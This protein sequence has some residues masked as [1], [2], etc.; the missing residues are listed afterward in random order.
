MYHQRM[1]DARGQRRL[2]MS[3]PDRDSQETPPSV[4]PPRRQPLYFVYS[5]FPYRLSLWSVRNRGHR[6]LTLRH[7]GVVFS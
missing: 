7:R 6:L 1:I 4:Y 5:L 3:Q 2:V